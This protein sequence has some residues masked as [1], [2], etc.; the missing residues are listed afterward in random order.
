M[1]KQVLSA[2]VVAALAAVSCGTHTPAGGDG[3]AQAPVSARLARVEKVSVPHRVELFGTVE[4]ARTAA[5]STRVMATVTAVRVKV[6]D[7]VQAGQIL[8]EIDPQT[9]QGQEAQARGALAQAQAALALAER[10]H[11]RFKSLHASGAASELELDM[12]RMQFEQARGAVEQGRGAV[13][14]A[15]SVAKESRVVAP[16]AGRIAAKLVDVGDLAAP[17]RPLVMVESATG[18]RLAVSVPES[19]AATARLTRGSAVTARIDALPEAGEIA[20]VVVEMTPGANPAS[21][22]FMARLELPGLEAASGLSGRAW[23]SVGSREAV[24][25]PRDAIVLQGGVPMI[26]LRDGEG[27][28]RSRA[29]ALGNAVTDERVEILAG[30]GGGEEVLVGVAAVPSDGAPVEVRP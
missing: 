2:V 19:V 10:N 1:K 13:E 12:A 26:V 20:G 6:G 11:E 9:A 4:A 3:Q 21:H 22:S 30:V 28:A 25:V 18:S 5:V 16:F 14:A 27:R 8:V 17:G 29:V 15:S 7:A 24:T 23:V